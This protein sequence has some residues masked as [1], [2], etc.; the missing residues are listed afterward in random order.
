M[1]ISVFLVWET[2]LIRFK[3]S[4][5]SKERKNLPIIDPI[6]EDTAKEVPDFSIFSSDVQNSCLI[7]GPLGLS[8]CISR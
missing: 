3:S 7:W 8:H 6:I 5:S 2:T 1:I 4:F